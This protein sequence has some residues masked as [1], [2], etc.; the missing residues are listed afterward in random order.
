VVAYRNW[1][2]R[3]F[4]GQLR[5]GAAPTPWAA[6]AA[7]EERPVDEPAVRVEAV[8]VLDDDLDLEGSARIRDDITQLLEQGLTDLV[9]DVSECDFIDSVGISLLLTTYARLTGDGGTLTL[10]GAGETVRRTLGHAGIADLLL[11]D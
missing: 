3:E 1:V 7:T 9:I 8:I 2:L 10:T 4:L 6:E 5:E 11:G